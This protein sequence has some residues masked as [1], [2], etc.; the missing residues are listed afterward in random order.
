[1]LTAP[2]LVRV[3]WAKRASNPVRRGVALAHDLGCFSCHGTLGAGGL[4]D[5]TARAGEVPAWSGGTWMMYVDNDVQIREF[6]RDG[7]SQTRAESPTAKAE[8][9]KQTIVMPA[10]GELLSDRELDDLVAAFRVLA[11]MALP[12]ADTPER[13]GL[14][15]AQKWRCFDCHGAAGSGGL[16][17]PRSFTGTV[18][19]WYGPEFTDLVRARDE[20][21][22]WIREGT[23][24]RMEQ[25]RIATWFLGR[26]RL[27][28]PAYRNLEPAELDA[29]WAY[30][31]WLART[32]GGYRG[33]TTSP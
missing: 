32:D 3:Y 27:T 20:F 28:M 2:W 16:P 17:N 8:R 11:R 10:F 21:D 1:V 7:I 12:E 23:T 18:P 24:P 25:S 9:S 15:L 5:P 13:A 31:Q 26:Q 22:A 30:A 14:D 19:A 29:L 33:A 4:P 6:I